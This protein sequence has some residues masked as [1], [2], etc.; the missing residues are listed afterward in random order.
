MERFILNLPCQNKKEIT[1]PCCQN[2][3]LIVFIG[4]ILLFVMNNIFTA[5]AITTDRK[6][7]LFPQFIFPS[8]ICLLPYRH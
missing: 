2:A 6:R 1:I 3:Q 4:F 8:M 7:R 5:Y